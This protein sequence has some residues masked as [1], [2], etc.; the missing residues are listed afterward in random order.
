[1]KDP[2]KTLADAITGILNAPVISLYVFAYTIATLAPPNG[3]LLFLLTTA[4]A[5]VLPL[6]VI[7]LMLRKGL[8]KDMYA[9]DRKT[10]F[11]PF[12]GAVLCYL[13]GLLSLVA[14][15]APLMVSVL[16]AGY[17]INTVIM[18]LITLR[19]KISIHASGVAG[20]A[21]FLIYAFGIQF[22]WTW[23]LII[24]VGWARLRLR[25]HT[26]GQVVIG[27]F[28]TVALTYLQLRIFLP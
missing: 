7:Y 28:L 9:Y 10:R 27:F 21:T 1:M 5:T 13:L 12:L 8:L 24:P 18:M 14:A 11:K 22:W 25:A 20:P 15:S 16:M 4:F 23:L 19:W 6:V 26:Q 2:Q 3:L 17:L